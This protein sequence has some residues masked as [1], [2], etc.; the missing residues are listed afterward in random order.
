MWMGAGGRVIDYLLSV[1]AFLAVV[2]ALV[3]ISQWYDPW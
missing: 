2:W 1:I 3:I